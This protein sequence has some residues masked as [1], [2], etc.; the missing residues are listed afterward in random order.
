MSDTCVLLCVSGGLQAIA[1]LLQLDHDAN[2][3]TAE[4]YNITM[5]R[6]ACMALT[7]LTFGDGTNKALLCSMKSCMRALVAQLG[8]PNEDLRQV[9]A[10]VVRNLSWRADLASK[11]TLREVGAVTAL[12]MAAMEVKKESTLKSIL[13]ALW[14]LSAHCS[15]NKADICAVDG[16]MAFLV[17]TLVYKSPSK[18]LAIIENGGG[19]LRN[20]SSHIAIRE[21]YR[22]VLR[23]H[24][25]LHILLK[26]LRS[27]SL[28]IVSNACG[29]LWNLS[30]RCP[31][32]QKAL[33]DMGA[34][35]MLRNLVHSKHKMISMGSAAALKNLLAAKPAMVNLDSDRHKSSN[36]PTLHVRKQ[37]ALEAELDQNL[38]ETCDNMESPQGSPTEQRKHI[39]PMDG[40][41]YIFSSE[42]SGFY[43][44]ADSEHR[45]SLMRG[46]HFGRNASADSAHFM[47][48]KVRSPNRPVS[49]SG[50]Q[51]SVGSVHSDISH[52]RGRAQNVLAKTTKLLQERQNV[53]VD[54]RMQR[55]ST[56][57][58]RSDSGRPGPNSRIMKVMHEVAVN[59][60]IDPG[61]LIKDPYSVYLRE[62]HS[63]ESTPPTM[64]R[65]QTNPAL[66]SETRRRIP[67]YVKGHVAGYRTPDG[68]VHTVESPT[69]QEQGEKVNIQQ[70]MLA[71]RMENLHI[72]DEDGESHDQPI[73]YS[74]KYSDAPLTNQ[75]AS[76]PNSV[77][78]SSSSAFKPVPQVGNYVTGMVYKSQQQNVPNVPGS[79]TTTAPSTGDISQYHHSPSGTGYA[80]TDI[81]SEDQPTNF[82]IRYAE[83]VDDGHFA[84]EQ[85]INY[86]T[87]Y[88]EEA[89]GS[90]ADCKLEEARR[91]NDL[92]EQAVPNV[93]DDSMCTFQTEGTPLYFLSTATSMN[94]LS[95]KAHAAHQHHASVAAQANKDLK[96]A[97]EANANKVENQQYTASDK[98]SQSQSGSPSTER[99]TGATVVQAKSDTAANIQNNNITA[100]AAE[101]VPEPGLFSYNDNGLTASP[102]EK[103]THYS[104]EG[105]P[106]VLSRRSSLS[107]LHSSEAQ[108]HP[109]NNRQ[110]DELVLQSIDENNSLE[111][112]DS[113]SADV[114]LRPAN[115]DDS[116]QSANT[117]V[118]STSTPGGNKSVTFDENNEVQETPLMFS[119]CSS[120][121]S[122]TSFDAHSVH[123]SVVSEYSRRASEVVSPSEL[124]DSPSDTM[125][126]SPTH[127]KSPVKFD[128]D[129][130]QDTVEDANVTQI[131][132]KKTTLTETGKDNGH[133]GSDVQKPVVQTQSLFKDST[134]QYEMEGSPEDFSCATSL[135]ALTFDDDND[136]KI[137]KDPEMRRVPLGQEDELPEHMLIPPPCEREEIDGQSEHAQIIGNDDDDDSV[138]E[139]EEDM[140]AQCISMAMPNNSRKKSKRK[141]STESPVKKNTSSGIPKM[142]NQFSST[143]TKSA[144]KLPLKIGT[145]GSP[146][147][148]AHHYLKKS[149]RATS[150]QS[151]FQHDLYIGSGHDTPKM[152]D[153][154]GTPLNFSNATSLS[155]LSFIG[156]EVHLDGPEELEASDNL[157]IADDD[158]K[159]D[160]SSLGDDCEDLLSE[161]IQA[162]MPKNKPKKHRRSGS[163]MDKEGE[164][165]ERN[166]SS[167]PPPAAPQQKSK[168]GPYDHLPSN[169]IAQPACMISDTMR[170]YAVEGTPINFSR[171]ASPGLSDILADSEHGEQ[172]EHE[173]HDLLDEHKQDELDINVAAGGAYHDESFSGH[174]FDSPKQYGME[175]TP[176][177]FSRN[178]SLSSLSCD[179]DTETDV[180]ET[181]EKLPSRRGIIS[182]G[183]MSP[184]GLLSPRQRLLGGGRKSPLASPGSGKGKIPSRAQRSLT[185]EGSPPPGAD[186]EQEPSP[187]R[188]GAGDDIPKQYHTE[189]TPMCF[190]RNSSVSSLNSSDHEGMANRSGSSGEPAI[191]EE[192]AIPS[193]DPVHD[194]SASFKVEDTPANFSH[195]SSLSSLSVESLGF[196]PTPSESALL[197]ECI[198]AAMPKSKPG[199]KKGSRL[200]RSNNTSTSTPKD[201]SKSKSTPTEEAAS[202]SQHRRS[203][204]GGSSPSPISDGSPKNEESSQH[205][206]K[207]ERAS[208]STSAAP[209]AG[210]ARK[211]SSDSGRRDCSQRSP[212]QDIDKQMKEMSNQEMVL[213]A[214][215]SVIMD[216]I[217]YSRPCEEDDVSS[218]NHQA[219]TE[220]LHQQ[221]ELHID[222]RLQSDTSET[223]ED[224]NKMKEDSEQVDLDSSFDLDNRFADLNLDDPEMITSAIFREASEI[225]EGLE[226]A[227]SCSASESD[228]PIVHKEDLESTKEHE[229]I[230]DNESDLGCTPLD[231]DDFDLD[232]TKETFPDMGASMLS[233]TTSVPG[234]L[235]GPNH[236]GEEVEGDKTPQQEDDNITVASSGESTSAENTVIADTS[237]DRS[238]S[239]EPSFSDISRDEEDE[240]EI[241]P[242][243]E[244]ALEENVSVILS[245]LSIKR[246]LSSS[247]L[248][249]DLFIEHETLSLVSNDYTSD[250][251]SEVSL[252]MSSSSKTMSDQASEVSTA[253][254]SKAKPKKPRI[255]KPGEKPP[256]RQQVEDTSP[257]GIRGRR[258]LLTSPKS[259]ASATRSNKS[260]PP[261]K[262]IRPGVTP[263]TPPKPPVPRSNSGS[264]TP[265]KTSPPKTPPKSTSTTPPKGT[266]S[267]RMSIT[268]RGRQAAASGKAVN[269]PRTPSGDRATGRVGRAPTKPTTTSQPRAGAWTAARSS[270]AGSSGGRVTAKAKGVATTTNKAAAAKGKTTERPRPKG[271]IKQRTFTKDSPTQNGPEI[272]PGGEEEVDNSAKASPPG[273]NR[274]SSEL[275]YS[276]DA[277]EKAPGDKVSLADNITVR[278]KRASG[279]TPPQRQSPPS[280]AWSKALENS[281]NFDVDTSQEDGYH[282]PQLQKATQVSSRNP[283]PAV[284]NLKKGGGTMAGAAIKAQSTGNLTK[285]SSKGAINKTSSGT[286]LNK[287]GSNNSLGKQG[288]VFKV[289]GKPVASNVKKSDSQGSV[290]KIGG[291]T[292]QASGTPSRKSSTGSLTGSSTPV[293]SKKTPKPVVSKIASLWKKD[294]GSG[295]TKA[296]AKKPPAK[297]TG[298]IKGTVKQPALNK[299]PVV[300][301]KS[302]AKT[303]RK[304][305]VPT[306]SGAAGNTGDA[307]QGGKPNE[308]TALQRSSTYDKLPVNGQEGESSGD[309]AGQ[310]KAEWRK[311]YTINPKE[312]QALKVATQSDSLDD[313]NAAMAGALRAAP[314]AQAEPKVKPAAKKGSIWRRSVPGCKAESTPKAKAAAATAASNKPAS[315]KGGLW[316]KHTSSD[317]KANN[318][319]KVN[320][321]SNSNSESK[322]WVKQGER[323]PETKISSLKSHLPGFKSHI[324]S[325]KKTPLKDKKPVNGHVNGKGGGDAE[326]YN[327]SQCESPQTIN[328][329]DKQTVTVYKSPNSPTMEIRIGSPGAIAAIVAPFNYNPTPN[330]PK[331]GTVGSPS[332]VHK[333]LANNTTNGDLDLKGSGPSSPTKQP[334]TKTE[335]LIA[336]R[337]QS[338]LNSIK[339]EDP[340]NPD[341]KK[342]LCLMTTV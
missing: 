220:Q 19:I 68:T 323:K 208:T 306:N 73:N 187:P 305:L 33:W 308:K 121:G 341:S 25:C 88:K 164:G 141:T 169:R 36:M 320:G 144:S 333:Q 100:V 128:H 152:F 339:A 197:E 300:T 247:T 59:A 137:T 276:N 8:S 94:D 80:E 157:I 304:S 14:N 75:N 162:A 32:D 270:S 116:Y 186:M 125:P 207:A 113:P 263:R 139:G 180:R 182:P 310:T 211:S 324:P 285:S 199:K 178:D 280:D 122:L 3:N 192:E 129:D 120:L 163:N 334:M 331:P 273:S 248:D 23:D 140:L 170:T 117:T 194:H 174:H 38:A 257:K 332:T 148:P 159:S 225:A 165:S 256:L 143:P 302:A 20:I 24:G 253:S 299:K 37:R 96:Q 142:N 184:R 319:K 64:R 27:P 236:Q 232:I 52:D 231:V 45:R 41:K 235:P 191:E 287:S 329:T 6:Y 158:D 214:S 61:P 318:D 221:L 89:D 316:R 291:V 198:N 317:T 57:D 49:R 69:N 209:T 118:E 44:V 258:K 76:S 93:N 230:S 160:L 67:V 60:G 9:A 342:D 168:P 260:D 83:Q 219:E 205:Q 63:A 206:N 243:E 267:G 311:T 99:Q 277:Q 264:K 259:N 15:E 34:V 245:E 335:M 313:L 254:Q 297:A 92:V 290:K 227:E 281:S 171:A 5:R 222:N 86:S 84:E 173:L 269:P 51:D 262:V 215:S 246:E 275:K 175:G 18:T 74:L 154:E 106:T 217:D 78:T 29:T 226:H 7:N 11:K 255:V 155:D 193:E 266:A 189:G 4:Q 201:K 307:K 90:C 46:H 35:S 177:T 278:E 71:Q 130:T 330:G 53:N 228:G 54:R 97:K 233:S 314:L 105:T 150:Q 108:D 293:S 292:G 301:P 28:T 43:Q 10:S 190:S 328:G 286:S 176:Q 325:P 218:H 16:S 132:T 188:T 250:T 298:I 21:D 147:S 166:Q 12:T 241:S 138:S 79:P 167:M 288:G 56:G 149:T 234:E 195:N 126:P 145:T 65:S 131:E 77:A 107:S 251:A 340:E 210:P 22:K 200:P 338:Y 124:P 136:V 95:C 336:R 322:V 2:G 237:T 272:L 114:T 196:E 185:Y 289:P 70:Q 223:D 229:V 39:V 151:E 81:D 204:R 179:E 153:T 213:G 134:Q 47:E 294:T 309:E 216:N 30:A 26:H 17:T 42:N 102:S 321:A 72:G 58:S 312:E 244:R 212:S 40:P 127:R 123:S 337:R 295:D 110:Q 146:R 279:G 268:N 111:V 119:R 249:E 203:S 252:C 62:S 224:E 161:A 282:D 183:T 135:S 240:P 103:P 181:K 87:R 13:S 274:S 271:P 101:T 48:V 55:Y 91:T 82:S 172:L 133:S 326:S 284:A 327:D 202:S 31:E 104:T 98:Q 303:G 85:P 112:T 109:N 50:S 242:E 1:E 265:T 156:E 296:P 283:P 239:Q 315:K 115:P 238:D 261:V 66:H